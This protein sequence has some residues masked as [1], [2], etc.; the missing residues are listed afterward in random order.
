MQALRI[1]ILFLGINCGLGLLLAQ[2][3]GF[4]IG[5]EHQIHSEILHE[6]RSYI[7]QLP[8]SYENDDFY[9][10]KRY[11]VAILLD[12]GRLFHLSS[13]VISSLGAG[14]IEEIPEM[15][16]V[17]VRNTNRN[18]DF[19]PTESMLSSSGERLDQ[20]AESGGAAAFHSFLSEELLPHIDSIY[21]TE[22][23]RLLIGHSFAGLFAAYSML[24]HETFD[25]FLAIDPS[26]W[27]DDAWIVKRLEQNP[28]D[29]FARFYIAQASNPFNPG[30]D[31]SQ[32][33]RAIQAFEAL[34]MQ[35]RSLNFGYKYFPDEDHFSVPLPALPNGLKMLFSD[36]RMPLASLA[37]Q[38][39][40]AIKQY[41]QRLSQNMGYEVLPPGR[42]FNQ[43]GMFLLSD[44]SR[45]E[46]ALML[47][48]INQ[49]H[50]PE[51]YLPWQSLGMAYERLRR[52]PEAIECY[53]QVLRLQP[54]N[55]YAQ[56]GVE[57]LAESE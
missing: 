26:L 25:A 18:R 28:P 16:L 31:V 30:P 33:G 34:M 39:S 12:G 51:S 54:D 21:R 46:Q 1:C 20:L 2:E 36:Y 42:L 43:I 53:R 55:A 19:L 35:N 24:E 3:N 57:R 10:E 6:E 40:S 50:Y 29:R 4:V 14:G 44:S 32:S 52:R 17:A 45:Q 37:E 38:D 13:G 23:F 47:L 22:P 56:A 41:Y 48:R 7:V 5:T 49:R 27:W 11:P 15:I 8:A 9:L